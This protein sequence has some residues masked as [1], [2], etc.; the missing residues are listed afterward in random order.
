[1]GPQA[2]GLVASVNISVAGAAGALGAVLG[3]AV[4]AVGLGL[5]WISPVASVPVLAA[6]GVAVRLRSRARVG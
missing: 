4:L 1:V 6:T 3:G 5:T 2:A